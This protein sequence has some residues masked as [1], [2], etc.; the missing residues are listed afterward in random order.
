MVTFIFAGIL[1]FTGG[2]ALKRSKSQVKARGAQIVAYLLIGCGMLV[3]AV[4][5]FTIVV[6][7]VGQYLFS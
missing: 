5:L 1:L 3:F 6:G 4:D 2:I 7:P